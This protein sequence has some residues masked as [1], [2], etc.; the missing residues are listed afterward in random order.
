MCEAIIRVSGITVRVLAFLST[1]SYA[2]LINRR[3]FGQFRTKNYQLKIN[4]KL[5]ASDYTV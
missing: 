1:N 3:L 2:G 4:S 5:K